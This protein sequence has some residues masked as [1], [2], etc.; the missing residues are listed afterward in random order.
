[1]K[2]SPNKP[3]H[4]TNQTQLFKSQLLPLGVAT[5]I[6]TAYFFGLKYLIAKN[7]SDNQ[8]SY[9]SSILT[10]NWTASAASI[11]LGVGVFYLT[12]KIIDVF[13]AR[14]ISDKVNNL[15]K[16]LVND[17]EPKRNET[18]LEE[19]NPLVSTKSNSPGKPEHV[20]KPIASIEDRFDEFQHIF[21]KNPFSLHSI[22]SQNQLNGLIS[23]PSEKQ[24][25]NILFTPY[26]VNKEV[27]FNDL[28]EKNPSLLSLSVKIPE[29]NSFVLTPLLAAIL[30]NQLEYLTIILDRTK[31]V[32]R[33]DSYGYTPAHYAAMTANPD[34]LRL[35]KAKE[36]NFHLKNKFG[37]TAA[38]LLEIQKEG[39]DKRENFFVL[40]FK[41]G[42]GFNKEFYLLRFKC[43]YLPCSIFSS[44]GLLAI[45]FYG[46]LNSITPK[47]MLKD[48]KHQLKKLR[49]TTQETPKIYIQNLENKDDGSLL[50]PLLKGQLEARAREKIVAGEVIGEY[51]GYHTHPKTNEKYLNDVKTLG[52]IYNGYFQAG[53]G[54]NL[55]SFINHGPPNAIPIN[56]F[57]RGVPHEVLVALRPIAKDEPVY[58]DYTRNYFDVAGFEPEEFAPNALRQFFEE[59]KYFTNFPHFHLREGKTI[60]IFCNKEGHYTHKEEPIKPD[61]LIEFTLKEMYQRQMLKYLTNFS[62]SQI[63][64]LENLQKFLNYT[65]NVLKIK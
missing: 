62:E 29:T 60:S 18:K 34:I 39:L 52:N 49:E 47:I 16:N 2:V 36:A 12:S 64:E 31:N 14:F 9:Q 41:K 57:Y 61:Q 17:K 5:G 65:T 44:S 4:N 20:E 27:L 63:P 28:L 3:L 13:T 54:G 40:P 45:R 23:D 1:M 37:A 32:N 11:A 38:D 35:L 15:Q 55:L 25:M 22:I 30:N 10:S 6:G 8:S 19:T 24:L 50:S 59:T 51:T 21:E 58:F 56:I 48:I 7:L 33:K 42:P 43:E 26:S 46:K 53:L